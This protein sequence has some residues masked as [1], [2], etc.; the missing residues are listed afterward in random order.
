MD[1]K[2]SKGSR[3]D[4]LKTKF[5]VRLEFLNKVFFLQMSDEHYRWLV[6][7][8]LILQAQWMEI[9]LLLLEKVSLTESTFQ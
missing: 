2:A 6:L 7:E 1:K 8:P 5:N 3:A 4:Q 9:D